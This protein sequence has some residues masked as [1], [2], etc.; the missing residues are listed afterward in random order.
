MI[1]HIV[2]LR[3]RDG[4]AEATKSGLMADLAALQDRIEGT[5]GF[6]VRRNVSP[7]TEMVRG[8]HDLFWFDFRDASVRDAYLNDP[9]HQEIGG[10]LV[11]ELEGGPEGVF[12]CDFEL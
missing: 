5:S 12:V 9:V 6:E 8:F 2:A 1:R 10:R 3:F 4:T 7:E 11:A